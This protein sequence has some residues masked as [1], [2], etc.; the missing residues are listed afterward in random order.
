MNLL[1]VILFYQFLDMME[2]TKEHV[3]YVPMLTGDKLAIGD[4]QLECFASFSPNRHDV[5]ANSLVFTI[6]YEDF[7]LVKQASA[8]LDSMNIISLFKFMNKA[9]FFGYSQEVVCQTLLDRIL[10]PLFVLVL[11]VFIAYTAWN[12]RLLED[13]L[14]K[15]K[16]V[17]VFPIFACSFHIIYN[18]LFV[19]FRFV[20]YGFLSLVG[21]DFALVVGIIFYILLL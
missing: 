9:T 8:D 15:F 5:N 7:D 19:L 2:A 16:W 18:I 10:Y 20:N 13:K 17:L 1:E 21:I 14:F 4:L 6:S 3:D 11:L 12:G